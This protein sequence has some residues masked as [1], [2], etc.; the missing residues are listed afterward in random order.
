MLAY[1]APTPKGYYGTEGGVLEIGC[2]MFNASFTPN[3]FVEVEV[4]GQYVNETAGNIYC[5]S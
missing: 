4:E 5:P 1:N 2:L 3:D